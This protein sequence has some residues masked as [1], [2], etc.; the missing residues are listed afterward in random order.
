ML[1]GL[2]FGL[3]VVGGAGGWLMAAQLWFAFVGAALV[4]IDAAVRRLPDHLTAAAAAGVALLLGGATIAGQPWVVVGRALAGAAAV[5]TLFFVAVLAGAVAFGDLKLSPALGALLAWSSWQAVA[6]GLLMSVFLAPLLVL[7]G[8]VVVRRPAR[9]ALRP[10]LAVTGLGLAVAGGVAVARGTGVGV[11]GGLTAWAL[12]VVQLGVVLV[13]QRRPLK[14]TKVAV[15]PALIAGS[16]LAS[17]AF[18]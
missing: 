12:A 5:G 7:V 15:G 4:L 2:V 18:S 1:T 3:V 13:A 11:L 8:L 6:A 17:V 14:G 16:L 9:R 10:V